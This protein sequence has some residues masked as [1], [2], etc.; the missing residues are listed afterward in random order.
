MGLV[1]HYH[2][3]RMLVADRLADFEREARVRRLAAEARRGRNRQ[4]ASAD[5]APDGAGRTL[6]D[7]RDVPWLA[8]E[9]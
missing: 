4:S 5:A 3:Y 9:G 7:R 8:C 2:T 1:M 6:D